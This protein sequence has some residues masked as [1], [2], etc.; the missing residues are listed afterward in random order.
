[1]KQISL[2][3]V[4]IFDTDKIYVESPIREFK[5]VSKK[6][7]QSKIEK[8]ETNKRWRTILKNTLVEFDDTFNKKKIINAKAILKLCT[9]IKN[10]FF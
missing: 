10:L 3:F 2:N 6:I 4:N 1:M 5:W 8:L 7:M 9:F